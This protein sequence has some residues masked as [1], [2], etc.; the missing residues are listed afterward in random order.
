M[1][2]EIARPEDTGA[3]GADRNGHRRGYLPITQPV[4]FAECDCRA[5]FFGQTVENVVHRA[6]DVRSERQFL[7]RR[8][9]AQARW[10]AGSLVVIREVDG[11]FE[12]VAAASFQ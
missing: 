11:I 1:I 9:F 5:M 8:Q 2:D 3:Y 7:G 10:M 4:D 12:Q 6:A